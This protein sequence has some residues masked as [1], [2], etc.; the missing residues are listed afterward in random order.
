MLN[1]KS[2]NT[3]GFIAVG[4]M[5]VMLVLIWAQLVPRS[6]YMPLFLIAAALFLARITL[7]L[8]L[9]RQERI[10]KK[11]IEANSKSPGQPT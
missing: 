1:Q 3:F 2:V 10:A 11:T 8:V 4:L 5:A 6:M 9:A 7:R